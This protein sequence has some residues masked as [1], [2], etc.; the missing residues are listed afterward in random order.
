MPRALILVAA[1]QWEQT[2]SALAA[3]AGTGIV[4]VALVGCA[5]AAV[6]VHDTIADRLSYRKEG[7]P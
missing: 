4:L 1:D 2:H 5:I 3:V 6:L 7:R